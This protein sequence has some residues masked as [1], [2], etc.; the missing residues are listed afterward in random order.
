MN[1]TRVDNR[2]QFERLINSVENLRI[3]LGYLP[4]QLA[5]RLREEMTHG[6]SPGLSADQQYPRSS[7]APPRH[8]T[9]QQQPVIDDDNGSA[10]TLVDQLEAQAEARMDAAEPNRVRFGI[11]PLSSF[12]QLDK[13]MEESGDVLDKDGKLVRKGSTGAKKLR[14]P[15]MPFVAGLKMFGQCRVSPSRSRAP[16]DPLSRAA[17]VDQ[18]PSQPPSTLLAGAAELVLSPAHRA[19]PHSTKR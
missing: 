15:R 14:G 5:H 6:H 13:R 1:S 2:D 11:N 7:S 18:R 16:A 17:Q 12:A 9:E 4:E 3:H 10:T 8:H 19:T